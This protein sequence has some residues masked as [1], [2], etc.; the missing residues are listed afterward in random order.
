MGVLVRFPGHAASPARTKLDAEISPPVSLSIL[1]AKGSDKPRWPLRMSDRCPSEQPTASAK[2]ERVPLA[3]IKVARRAKPSMPESLPQV[4]RLRQEEVY[5]GKIDISQERAHNPAMARERTVIEPKL[6][7]GEWIQVL[8]LKQKDV[9]KKAGIGKSYLNLICKRNR[10]NPT[11]EVLQN[12][13]K[14]MDL[15]IKDLQG[16]P[17][18][19]RLI[20]AVNNIPPGQLDRLRNRRKAS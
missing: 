13:A 15:T 11:L 16:P 9:A 7:I 5:C 2:A 6:Y 12:I 8:G 17:P 4:N 14:A 10:D 19:A 1:T 20:D 3:S 18:D